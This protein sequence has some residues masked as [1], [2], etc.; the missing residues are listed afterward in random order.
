MGVPPAGKRLEK[1]IYRYDTLKACM[2]V[3]H[4]ILFM[5]RTGIV[6]TTGFPYTG[7]GRAGFNRTRVT[8]F[9]GKV[10][11]EMRAPRKRLRPNGREEQN[12]DEPL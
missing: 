4:R 2:Q 7:K 8:G 12:R 6:V 11:T 3:A 1:Y 10:G 5:Y 9:T